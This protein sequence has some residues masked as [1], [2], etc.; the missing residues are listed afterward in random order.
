MAKMSARELLTRAQ[1]AISGDNALSDFK[2]IVDDIRHEAKKEVQS[3][4]EKF[5]EARRAE[6]LAEAE[7]KSEVVVTTAEESESET[8]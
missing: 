1:A 7:G 8:A 6:R 3:E 5:K 2:G 4:A